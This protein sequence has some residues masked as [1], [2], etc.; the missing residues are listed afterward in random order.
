MPHPVDTVVGQAA[1]DRIN[2]HPHHTLYHAKRIIGREY[3]H[4]SVNS[5]KDEVDFEVLPKDE[6]N[7]VAG[8]G[9][10]YHLPPTSAIDAEIITASKAILTPSQIGSYVIHHLR[11]LTRTHLGHDNVQSAVIAIPAK[12]E[13]SQ[14][15]ATIR[16]FELAGLKV[17]RILEEPTAA[18]LAYGLHKRDDVHY[19]IDRKSVV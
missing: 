14:R 7:G 17:A 8:F 1:K 12:F 10:P 9:F 3:G 15:D 11:T 18:A 2:S 13:P 19:V 6:K 5:L 16:A 4:E